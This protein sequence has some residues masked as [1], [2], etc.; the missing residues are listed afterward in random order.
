MKKVF[1]NRAWA[2]FIKVLIQKV[3]FGNTLSLKSLWKRVRK[4][5]NEQKTVQPTFES[6][7][8]CLVFLLTEKGSKK[9]SDI[10]EKRQKMEI[11]ESWW[12]E[13]PKGQLYIFDITS[14]STGKLGMNEVD[15]AIFMVF[16]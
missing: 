13:S 5:A 4:R 11:N 6:S 2:L 1:K 10:L 12:S 15:M 3:D 7:L 9:G 14:K 8:G 16:T